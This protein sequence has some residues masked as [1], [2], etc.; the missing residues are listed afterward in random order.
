MS[1]VEDRYDEILK[2]RRI[3]S[4]FLNVVS[5]DDFE[6][7][8]TERYTAL[9]IV[10]TEGPGTLTV[11]ELARRMGIKPNTAAE[12][13]KRMELAGLIARERRPE[14]LREVHLSLTSDGAD[15][16]DRLVE[17]DLARLADCKKRLAKMLNNES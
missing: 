15:L 1:L 3:F 10:R 8:G 2:F 13:T 12:L 4:H 16:V 11:G 9:L 7:L 14:N 5:G 17:A 6:G